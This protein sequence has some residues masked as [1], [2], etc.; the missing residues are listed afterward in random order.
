MKKFIIVETMY[1]ENGIQAF[2]ISLAYSLRTNE[3]II[4]RLE[5]I[6]NSFRP[7]VSLFNSTINIRFGIII[8]GILIGIREIFK[9][10]KSYLLSSKFKYVDYQL[11]VL[12]IDVSN[13]FNDTM[14]S[15]C[16]IFWKKEFKIKNWLRG[17]LEISY[18]NGF[19]RLINHL[20]DNVSH[21]VTGDS[22]YRYGYI[23]K[24]A[25]N[26]DLKLITNLNLNSLYFNYY[27]P[28]NQE[29]PR[30][31]QI[32][33]SDLENGKNIFI[34]WEELIS[35]YIKRR[36]SGDIKQ[37]DV[38]NAYTKLNSPNQHYYI[39]APSK[40]LL[41]VTIFAHVFSDAPRNIEGKLFNNFYDW[42]KETLLALCTNKN[43]Y[44]FVREHPSSY[45][46]GEKGLANSIIRE[47]GLH[48]LVTLIP[49]GVST[50]DVLRNTDLVVTCSG[51]I[52]L[53]A[54]Y[55]GL[56]VLIAAKTAY[57]NLGLCYEFST[58]ND[59]IEFINSLQRTISSP[60]NFNITQAKLTCFIHFLVFNNRTRYPNIPINPFVRGVFNKFDDND[61][62][63]LY[64]FI[65]NDRLFSKDFEKIIKSNTTRYL[66]YLFSDAM[67][68]LNKITEI[69]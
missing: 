25:E 24:A 50:L 16:G 59:Y 57:S 62:L 48:E 9:F 53:E 63:Q 11:W 60:S 52:G 27:T 1:S 47:L 14:E 55:R 7:K 51:S 41:K 35:D 4:I 2:L 58:K 17:I 68:H 5:S 46:Y 56:P 38:L 66:P 3:E 49:D 40:N 6:K 26:F 8:C 19:I 45:L 12:D 10:T 42:F 22:A 65:K 39:N 20:K 15:I 18:A 61:A 36:E 37:H 43:A 30:S 13:E 69:E 21:V 28:H 67:P 23:T 33:T 29:Q 34:N 54:I 31:Y 44:I 64:E 32:T